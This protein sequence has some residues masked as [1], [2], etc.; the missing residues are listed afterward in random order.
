MTRTRPHP[1]AALALGVL[2]SAALAP[3]LT[4][5]AAQAV[6]PLQ[7]TTSRP[8]AGGGAPGPTDPVR[9][10]P[11]VLENALARF[12]FETAGGR[13]QLR[14]VVNKDPALAGHPRRAFDLDVDASTDGGWT[15]VFA[16]RDEYDEADPTGIDERYM[17]EADGGF[18]TT[19]DGLPNP[20]N[21]L[22]MTPPVIQG[23]D[24]L[25]LLP[26]RLTRQWDGQVTL[27]T[28]S[29]SD[30]F[31][32]Q[33]EVTWQ[34]VPGR[35]QVEASLAF[36]Y[37]GDVPEH[38]YLSQV[39]FPQMNLRRLPDA[40]APATRP[41]DALVVPVLGG[42]LLREPTNQTMPFPGHL[43]AGAFLTL[44]NTTIPVWGDSVLAYYDEETGSG[45]TYSTTDLGDHW[46]QLAARRVPDGP[47]QPDGRGLLGFTTAH[48]PSEALDN[49]AFTG[50]GW[51]MPYKVRVEAFRGDWWDVAEQRRR[52]LAETAPWYAGP[53]GSPANPMP[54]A[55]KALVAENLILSGRHGDSMDVRSR[56]GADLTE[57]LGAGLT[58]IWYHW[59]YPDE[60][61]DFLS[62]GYLPG[63]PSLAAAVREARAQAGNLV[64]LYINA[65]AVK[66]DGDAT[67]C[68]TALLDEL[69]RTDKGALVGV[70]P[71]SPQGRILCSGTDAW[72]DVIPRTILGVASFT[73]MAGVHL[74]YLYP[75]LCFD[76][77]HA[78]PTGGGDWMYR[79]PR[80]VLAELTGAG[81]PDVGGT[82]QP[83]DFLAT[84][85]P[86][87]ESDFLVSMESHTGAWTGV[88]DI[89][90]RNPGLLEIF[91]VN[92]NLI[93]NATAI[94]F[95][96][97]VFDNVKMGR[98]RAATSSKDNL[99]RRCWIEGTAVLR[100]GQ[101]IHPGEASMDVFPNF[102]MRTQAAYHGWLTELAHVLRDRGLL[103][104]HNGTLRRP[105]E[106]VVLDPPTA[107]H[108]TSVPSVEHEI[109]LPPAP[110]SG[111]NEVEGAQWILASTFQAPADAAVDGGSLAV[112][113]A[114]PWV[115]E[116]RKDMS[117][118]FS[119]DLSRHP[120]W[121]DAAGY[122][123]ERFSSREPLGTA[124]PAGASLAY[125]ATDTVRTGEI[126]WYVFRR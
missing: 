24:E 15:L 23:G 102:N 103:H 70:T 76:E 18:G 94:P 21:E 69:L 88:V 81:V 80:D 42:Y 99:G 66:I 104:W 61:E 72:A 101:M 106:L 1:L 37:V 82:G 125:S 57:V 107:W 8:R 98:T 93:H 60:F 3:A 32:F 40:G 29:E 9:A 56:F 39:G 87:A 84:A 112:V 97:A 36:R 73:G 85:P 121:E 22:L 31:R 48:Y 126:V 71:N 114:N 14:R 120:G 62:A 86:P 43:Q 17:L 123:V 74:D 78:H 25:E 45:L 95:F 96:R 118:Q 58:S 44:N 108:P 47:T 49:S 63:R 52:H 122:T 100:F 54:A 7:P 64:K 6:Q 53:V 46:K 10:N 55:A 38:V 28:N 20:A 116:E 30:S 124:L 91:A 79:V 115:V 27:G 12:E 110:F 89:M 109:G 92:G 59:H 83:C 75:V 11:S 33:V 111:V 5:A 2:A 35:P 90:H 50:D 68:E 105:P 65:F 4:P 16:R 19:T 41:P 113:L 34:L 119:L 67:S 13:L 26:G 117:V 51:R 77:T